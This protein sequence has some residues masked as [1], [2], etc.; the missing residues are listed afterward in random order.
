MP[1][2]VGGDEA[3]S[4]APPAQA[5]ARETDHV[6]SS[7]IPDGH[8]R[9][10]GLR[11]TSPTQQLDPTAE[12][13]VV[14]EVKD[15]ARARPRAVLG[16]THAKRRRLEP[17]ASD[18]RARRA[19]RRGAGPRLTRRWHW[20]IRRSSP[21]RLFSRPEVPHTFALLARSACRART[22][23]DDRDRAHGQAE[24]GEHEK[25]DQPAG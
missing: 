4:V 11:F 9:P 24:Q 6:G 13:G 19:L 23:G 14:G 2:K 17:Q 7:P 15:D 1:V 10:Y 8:Q 12:D 18:L 22:A 5:G 21:R 16:P 25:E 3:Q 20:L